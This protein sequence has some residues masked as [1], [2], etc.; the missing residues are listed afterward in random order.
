MGHDNHHSTPAET[1]PTASFRS[2]FWLVVILAGLFVAAVNFISVMGH[3]EDAG[4]ATTEH[5]APAH[6]EKAEHGSTETDI[7][8][9]DEGHE[10]HETVNPHQEEAPAEHGEEAHH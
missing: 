9:N 2:S 4:H 3:D 6:G 1:R 5:A 8:A 7:H 10:A